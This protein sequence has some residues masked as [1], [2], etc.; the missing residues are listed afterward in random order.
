MGFLRGWWRVE[1][2]AEDEFH[3]L[4][5]VGIADVVFGCMPEGVVAG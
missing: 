4:V 3:T 2:E 5:A 1:A